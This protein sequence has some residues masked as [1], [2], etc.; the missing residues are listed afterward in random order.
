MEKSSEIVTAPGT[1]T[2]AAQIR[3]A[4]SA[5]IAAIDRGPSARRP[6]GKDHRHVHVHWTPTPE[7]AKILEE[8]AREMDEPMDHEPGEVRVIGAEP[9]TRT[10]TRPTDGSVLDDDP[11]GSSCSTGD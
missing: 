6:E 11:E 4:T 9:A 1:E 3:A 8:T 10:R 5:A 7:Q 2:K